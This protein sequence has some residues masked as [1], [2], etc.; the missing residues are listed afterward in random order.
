YTGNTPA[1]T[2]S[3][4]VELFKPGFPVSRAVA[5]AEKVLDRS[6]TG[7][8]NCIT[9]LG[10]TMKWGDEL[11]SQMDFAENWQKFVKQRNEDNEEKCNSMLYH[12]MSYNKEWA[13][14]K[15]NNDIMGSMK[16][17][18]R[19]IYDI[20]RN[21]KPKKDEKMDWRTMKPFRQLII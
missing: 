9:L 8:K 3:A 14:V 18:F 12:F 1:I 2:I 21:L 13:D 5:N 20:N 4:G 17:R 19:F 7:G 15:K 11:K 16:H 10:H 6:K